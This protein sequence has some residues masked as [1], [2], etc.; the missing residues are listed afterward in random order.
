MNKIKFAALTLVLATGIASAQTVEDR[1]AVMDAKIDLVKKQKELQDALRSLAGTA[2]TG[3][4]VVVSVTIGSQRVAR[5]RLPNGIVGHY[6]EGEAVRPG[7]V[8]TSIAPKE[9]FVAVLNGKKALAVPLEFAGPVIA[10]AP[11]GATQQ[12]IP[13]ALLPQAPDVMVPA[14]EFVPDAKPA[15]PAKPAPA[16][17]AAPAQPAAKPGK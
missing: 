8:V 5:L 3:L 4:P 14:I 10:G 2:S 16:A 1:K 12:N 15:V 17:A 6:H 13:D 11:Q 7:M 9:V